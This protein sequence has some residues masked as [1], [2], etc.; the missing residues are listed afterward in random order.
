[1][2]TLQIDTEQLL[3][4]F[5]DMVRIDSP[6][7]EEDAL[8][9][10]LIDRVA[11][12]GLAHH[13]DAGGNLIVDIP[14]QGCSHSQILVFS[15][16]MDV[17]PPCH[18]IQP[19]IEEL[20]GD[21]MIT[22]D[23]TTVLGADDKAGLAPILEA[24]FFAIDHQLPMPQL[25]LIFTT[26]EEVFLAGAKELSAES[27]K[28]DFAITLDHTGK[29][30]VIINQAPAYIE[31]TIEC[32]GKS[33]HA[34]IMPE[35][36]VNAIVFASRV[37]SQLRLGRIDENTTSNIGFLTGGKATNI[38]P[39]LT[40]IKGE[41]RGH[42]PLTLERELAH[43]EKV[44]ADVTATLPGTGYKFHYQTRFDA[45]RVDE[46]HA[47]VQHVVS[48]AL[49][50]GLEPQFIRTNGG[51]DNNIFVKRGLPGVVL[52][53]GYMEPHSLKERVRLSEMVLCCQ[54]L[55]NILET[56]AHEPF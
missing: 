55:M 10:Y 51:S 47:G 15:G 29:Q 18:Q 35:Q 5:L 32:R 16:H 40:V 28:A 42:D 14:A 33:V 56:F 11:S 41:L 22:S 26:R 12:K 17:V 31:F 49:K 38:V 24:V 21:R 1:M 2:N 45:Y 13:T 9:D 50:T 23:N 25:R 6:S 8:R 54:F 4:T 34:G 7:G 52:S 46:T 30:G 36:G 53:A 37:I 20:D 43:I 19:I 27:L 3:Q 48:A 44:L 39:D